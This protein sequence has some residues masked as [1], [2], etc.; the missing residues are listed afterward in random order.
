MD[1]VEQHKKKVLSFYRQQKAYVEYEKK[2]K[3]LKKKFEEYMVEYMGNKNKEVLSID[4]L[5]GNEDDEEL[6]INKINRTSIE[7]YPDK[8]EKRITKKVAKKV[9]R[10]SYEIN[11]MKGLSKYLKSCGVNPK[12]FAKY[13][14]VQKEVDQDAI[15]M[16]GEIGE[17]T[18]QNI[19]G[20]YIVKCSKPYIKLSLRKRKNDDNEKRKQ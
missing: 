3:E 4:N 13:I 16:L 5:E 20:C 2:Y 8:L 17:I 15:D 18:P 1:N 14:T 6:L 9:I 7:W 12:V 11:D 10:K 19:S